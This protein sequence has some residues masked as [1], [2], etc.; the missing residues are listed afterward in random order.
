[1]L[2]LTE[3]YLPIFVSG[4]LIF[5]VQRACQTTFVALTEA[6]I[7]LFIAILRKIIL[8]VP[9]AFLFSMAIG[10]SGVYLAECVA[11][12][13][14]ATLCSIIFFFRFRAVL[15]RMDNAE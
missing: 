9:F 15:R 5:G 6:K 14:A 10:V 3:K 1:L 13:T 8:L 2:A 4:M 7:S 12:A 11:D